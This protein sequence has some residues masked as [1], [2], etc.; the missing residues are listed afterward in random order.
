MNGES[1]LVPA[2][3][4]RVYPHSRLTGEANVLIM[5]NIDAANIAYQMIKV[6]GRRASRSGRF[7]SARRARRTS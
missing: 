4:K 3:R 6:L 7:S 5:P 2:F 1:A